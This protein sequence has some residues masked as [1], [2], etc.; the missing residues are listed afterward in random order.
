MLYESVIFII[1]IT[2]FRL[3]YDDA[4]KKFQKENQNMY[5]KNYELIHNTSFIFFW[6]TVLV[7]IISIVHVIVEF[8]TN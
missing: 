6:L 1:I 3:K 8:L 4:V 7:F 5:P 2:F